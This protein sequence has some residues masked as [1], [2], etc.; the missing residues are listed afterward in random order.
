MA[1]AKFRQVFPVNKRP[2]KLIVISIV[3]VASGDKIKCMGVYP[4]PFEINK[5][6]FVYNLHVLKDLCN[7]LIL[8]L[9]FFQHAGLAYDPGNKKLF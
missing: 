3:T 5:K 7:N 2:K 1:A 6:K 4:I 9:N 8:A